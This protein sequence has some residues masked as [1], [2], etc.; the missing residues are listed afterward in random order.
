MPDYM[1]QLE[2]RLSPEQRAAMVRIQ[3]LASESEANLYLAG[4]AVRDVV[5]GMSIRDLDFTIEGNP[6]RIVRELEKGGARVT[7]ED[8]SLRATELVLSGDVDASISA[9]REDIYARPGAKPETRFST[10]M[11]DL[12]RRDFSIN[13]IAISLNPNSRG[14]LLDPTNGLADLERHEIR[15]LSIHSFTNQPV[16]L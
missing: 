6:A 5:S 1:F 15:A 16:R 11:E 14:L 8:D 3:E 7:R 4:G 12:R 13:A 9:A 2:S 10:I